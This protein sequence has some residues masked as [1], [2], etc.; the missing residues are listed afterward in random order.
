MI[1]IHGIHFY[2][3]RRR[4]VFLADR[5]ALWCFKNRIESTVNTN[6]TKADYKIKKKGHH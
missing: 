1:I 3:C 6:R 2:I 4:V 5:V